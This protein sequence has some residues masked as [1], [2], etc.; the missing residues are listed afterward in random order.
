MNYEWY[1]NMIKKENANLKTV[2]VH[3]CTVLMF[4]VPK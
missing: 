3:D 4:I 2:H 1:L